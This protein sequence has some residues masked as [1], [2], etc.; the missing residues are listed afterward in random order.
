MESFQ[1]FS[2]VV[3]VLGVLCGALW[4]LKRMG[5]TRVN[6][7]RTREDGQPRLEVVDRLSL[8]P[9]HSLLLVRLADRTL[10]IGLSP[11]NCNLLESARVTGVPATGREL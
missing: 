7:R 2:V 8:A 4:L 9:H 5:W 10:L 1:Q 3:L 11:H 6:L